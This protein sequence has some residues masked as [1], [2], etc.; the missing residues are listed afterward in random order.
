M[1]P[2]TKNITNNNKT[3]SQLVQFVLTTIYKHKELIAAFVGGL[4]VLTAWVFQDFLTELSY[5]TLNIAAF[6]IG[7]YAKAKEGLTETLKKR[8]LNVEL[9]MI[10]A[11]IGSAIIG[12]WV[13]GA[14]LIFI[15][16]LSGA[17][18]TYT[19]QK[20]ARDLSNLMHLQPDTALRIT[21]GKEEIV[22][23]DVLAIGDTIYVKPG[24][25]MPA[26][27][28]I[29][30]GRTSID[31]SALTG[32]A[33]PIEK[34]VDDCVYTGTVNQ[35]G[36]LTVKVTADASQSFVQKIMALVRSAQSEKSP[37]QLFIERFENLYVYIVLVITALMMVL[38]PFIVNWSW[39]ESFYRA[40][41]LLVVAS[42]CAL[43]ASISPA[44]L[45]AIST[46]ARHG[47]LVKSGQHLE[48]LEKVQAIA[49]DKTGT[50]TVGRPEVT[51]IFIKSG[52]N[53]T[54]IIER[55]VQIEKGSSH[56]L[57]EAM[58][59]FSKN[60]LDP[61][62][63]EATKDMTEVIGKGVIATFHGERWAIGN[64]KLFDHTVDNWYENEA[65]A[66][67]ET[68]KT[69][70]YVC[71][72]NDVVAIIALKDEI[73][74]DTL[75]A[76]KTFHSLGIETVMLTGDNERTAEAIAHEVGL[77]RYVASC[78]PEDKVTALKSLQM[79][80][81]TVMMVGDGI[82]DAPALATANIG[83][84][85]GAGTDVALE[86]ADIVLIKN[87]LAKLVDLFNLSKQMN[88]IIKQNILFS[89]S[90]IV[91]LVISNLFQFINLP[92]GVIG[93]EGSTIL[94]ILNG[95]R[96]LKIRN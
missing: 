94:V 60:Y 77:T 14:I 9:L 37:A 54:T 32:E 43:V 92:L 17:M 58:I 36:A 65:T 40:M 27:G 21:N 1:I 63:V 82:N 55:I 2:L 89:I 3:H 12:Y 70:V 46:S 86:T 42:P 51:N 87:K 79:T 47:M 25:R 85:M 64:E 49:F 33:I 11:A 10:L 31:E 19:M 44:T 28:I 34:S 88:K 78:M 52:E 20:S 30:T 66:L 29:L 18:E 24:E 53:I 26:D 67:K 8:T 80:F 5:I 74:Q 56:P 6:I 68:A 96:L 95:L 72:N 22:S 61:S 39:N 69:L 41:I 35:S 91:L 84:A 50:L 13:E 76:I 59:R 57:A 62:K 71:K 48:N 15:F 4:L 75:E 83:V 73:R 38:P 45:S 90:I 93:H 16:S 23:V 81:D 7:G